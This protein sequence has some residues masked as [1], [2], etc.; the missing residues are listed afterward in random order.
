M[1]VELELKMNELNG[2]IETLRKKAESAEAGKVT[3]GEVEEM[4]AK[5]LADF[6]AEKKEIKAQL[7]AL[8]TKMN[9]PGIDSMTGDER[10]DAQTKAYD[11][12]LR[13]GEQHLSADEVKLLSSDNDT[14]G[15]YLVTPQMGT[16]IIKTV[17]DISPIRQ[18]CNSITLTTAA[19]YMYPKESGTAGVAKRGERGTVAATTNPTLGMGKIPTH[20]MYAEPYTTQ[21]LLD[22]T[23]FNVEGW[24]AGAVAESFAYEEGDWFLNGD[25]V[26]EAEGIL[27]NPTVLAS[28]TAGGHGTLLNNFDKIR[29]LKYSLHSK[30]RQ[31]ARWLMNSATELAVSLL[32]DGEGRYLWAASTTEGS[33]TMLDGKAI[34]NDETMP[35]IGAGTYPILFGDYRR[36]YTIVDKSQIHVIRDNVTAKGFVKFYTERRVGGGVVLAEAIKPLKIAAS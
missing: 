31:N 6:E 20:I 17:R 12:F 5:M 29:S 34:I 27:T 24:L 15:G 23:G 14:T 21:V 36:G 7:E 28:Y 11:S 10:K 9:R 4:Q 1:S 26:T 8:E 19:E 33:P 13:K 2:M 16:E 18:Y 25:G 35:D 32:K 22:D 3:K 30:Y